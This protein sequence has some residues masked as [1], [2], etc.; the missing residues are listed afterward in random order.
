MKTRG[1]KQ[2]NKPGALH[3]NAME[4]DSTQYKVITTLQCIAYIE[5]SGSSKQNLPTWPEGL[6][7]YSVYLN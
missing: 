3:S 1:Q 7:N 4:N 5:N 6:L 2:V